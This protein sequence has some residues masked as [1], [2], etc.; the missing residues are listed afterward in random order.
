VKRKIIQIA[1]PKDSPDSANELFAL[2]DD[3]TVWFLLYNEKWEP[4]WK[5][6]EGIPQ[7]ENT[8]EEM[9]NK[10]FKQYGC[11]QN[12]WEPKKEEEK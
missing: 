2:C 3:G 9:N 8:E 12:A 4:K 7:D 1:P 10:V 6:I 5:M 11:L